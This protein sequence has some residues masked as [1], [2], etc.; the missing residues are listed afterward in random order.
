[1]KKYLIF[2]LAMILFTG[3]FGIDSH[4]AEIDDYMNDFPVFRLS[5]TKDNEEVMYTA[6]YAQDYNKK[7]YLL[8]SAFVGGAMEDGWTAVLHTSSGQIKVEHLLTENG[9]SYLKA[10]IPKG[11]VPVELDNPDTIGT[12]EGG[13]LLCSNKV[14]KEIDKFKVTSYTWQTWR[15]EFSDWYHENGYYLNEE[16][17][18]AE[19]YLEEV[20]L[21]GAPLLEIYADHVYLIGTLYVDEYHRPVVRDFRVTGFSESGAI[22]KTEEVSKNMNTFSDDMMAQFHAMEVLN[23]EIFTSKD[24]LPEIKEQNDLE[25]TPLLLILVGG[26][27]TVAAVLFL[28]KG[29]QKI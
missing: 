20:K 1:M 13:R 22:G 28:K 27:A 8:S 24:T 29:K 21:F 26:A 4:A 19:H 12:I 6:F 10:E 23:D 5:L 17:Y 7:T 9:V 3:I 11:Y 16:Q 2:L 25:N 14:I 15:V 18:L